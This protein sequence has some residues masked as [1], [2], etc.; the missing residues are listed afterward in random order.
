MRVITTVSKKTDYL[1][2]GTENASPSKISKARK[3]GVK[4]I[5]EIE[6]LE[7]LL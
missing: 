7:S 1:V 4:I 2:C 5:N 3:L 6:F